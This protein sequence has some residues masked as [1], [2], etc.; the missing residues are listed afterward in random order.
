[1]VS[2]LI[3]TV[4]IVTAPVCTTS[5]LL[6]VLELALCLYL[7]NNHVVQRRDTVRGSARACVCVSA[8]ERE[9]DVYVCAC[10]CVS[11][12]EREVD[13][14]VCACV[15]VSADERE[16]DVYVCACVCVCVCLQMSE[17]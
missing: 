1:M 7:C 3:T 15:C 11:A 6:C 12:D 5:V 16:V 17:R 13:V 4:L 14:Y 2:D 8:D 10:V 9:V